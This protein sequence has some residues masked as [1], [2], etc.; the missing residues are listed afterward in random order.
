MRTV[1]SF[2]LSLEYIKTPKT[3]STHLICSECNGGVTPVISPLV[4]D[5]KHWLCCSSVFGQFMFTIAN[6]KQLGDWTKGTWSHRDLVYWTPFGNLPLHKVRKLSSSGNKRRQSDSISVTY[7][8]YDR[9]GSSVHWNFLFRKV[10]KSLIW[11]STQPLQ[12]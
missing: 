3:V 12:K 11:K 2:A 9:R 4:Q 1:E 10:K 8:N 5:W 7:A 6:Y